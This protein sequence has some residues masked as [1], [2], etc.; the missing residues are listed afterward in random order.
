[1]RRIRE[2]RQRQGLTGVE[3]ARLARVH[4]ADVSSLECGR[5]TPPPTSPTLQRLAAALDWAG[6]PGALLE[7]V[8]GGPA[9]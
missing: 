3:L 2:L 1:M 4:P 8:D 9:A 6:E 5:R 7:E